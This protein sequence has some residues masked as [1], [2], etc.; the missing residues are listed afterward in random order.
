[1]VFND[2][3]T[4]ITIVQKPFRFRTFVKTD[5][6]MAKT[7]ARTKRAA[8]V[9][10]RKRPPV[11]SP[12][13]PVIV[14]NKQRRRTTVVRNRTS[15]PD[16]DDDDDDDVQQDNG[17]SPDNQAPSRARYPVGGLSEVPLRTTHTPTIS[18][19]VDGNSPDDQAPSRARYPVGGLSDVPLCTTHTPTVSC[20]VSVAVT[21]SPRREQRG[22]VSNPS[23]GDTTNNEDDLTSSSLTTG[24]S[25]AAREHVMSR[26]A[27][28]VK[29]VVFKKLKFITT[30]KQLDRV[31]EKVETHELVSPAS[32]PE[33][34]RVYKKTVMSALND[35]RS[36]CGQSGGLVFASSIKEL[37]GGGIDTMYTP[38]ELMELSKNPDA[39]FWFVAEFLEV[40]AGKKSWGKE[41]YFQCVQ[42]CNAAGELLVT[43]SD[44]AYA[45]FIYENY[46]DKWVARYE[47]STTVG[48][49]KAKRMNG[50][51]TSSARGSREFGG[52]NANGKR[53]YNE[54]YATVEWDRQ[55]QERKEE[56]ERILGLLQKTE[57]GKLELAKVQQPGATASGN[58]AGTGDE[59]L[60]AKDDLV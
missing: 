30:M 13:S 37:E 47:E 33:F 14:A 46:Y 11:Q 34:R 7:A 38:G 31:F 40:V 36:I 35:K 32:S 2:I 45:L 49:T 9:D 55:R 28:F 17:N 5:C 3:P 25:A 10:T 42:G 44:E 26:I 43:V 54:L 22:E 19:T 52:L 60:E 50:K 21:D 18:C 58:T 6:T 29:G 59:D 57:R 20:T 15:R 41:K 48:V 53:R 39:F 51:F 8:A 12:G 24:R 23:A 16:I 27:D 4:I 1:M 56:E